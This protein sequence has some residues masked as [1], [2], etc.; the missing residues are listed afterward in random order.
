[1]KK[2][3][4]ISVEEY[5]ALKKCAKLQHKIDNNIDGNNILI[6]G[7]GRH[8][9]YV[10]KICVFGER[11][12]R[13]CDTYSSGDLLGYLIEKPSVE[14]YEWADAIIIASYFDRKNIYNK[15][16]ENKVGQEK[17]VLLYEDED[18][19][20][21]YC[22]EVE[23]D[24]S[25]ITDICS[26]E[27]YGTQNRY[28]PWQAEG[29][30]AE[31]ERD[32]EKSFF[33]E[34][35]K[36]YFLKWIMPGDKVADIGAGTGRLS[37]E[38]K[39]MGA[40][41]TAIDTSQEMLNILK[42]KDSSISTCL[43]KDSCIPFDDESFDKVVS[44]DTMIHF[45]NWKDFL[46]EHKRVVKINGY[47]IYNMFNDEHLL[48]ISAD[49]RVRTSYISDCYGYGNAVNRADI[50]QACKEIGG[51]ELVDMIPYGFLAQTAFA[52]GIL[53]HQ[54][55]L[56]LQKWYFSFF[57]NETMRRLLGKFEREIVSKES[58]TISAMNII[59][60]RKTNL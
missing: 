23:M 3:K 49:K 17:I 46:I 60:L 50:K 2:K 48:P 53:T 54:E 30:G 24:A 41:V 38:I 6:F 29:M 36:N 13:I 5:E 31:Y 19:Q 20:P 42:K 52:Y 4:V 56:S 7:A 11:Q 27:N 58:E 32:V 21:I 43:V 8:A 34:I 35:T 28:T 59:I 44:C 39:K 18:R 9:E 1:M 40:G 12:I 10:L 14:A 26:R 22:Y 16:I 57:G 33:S 47:I 55:M 37:I 25:K 51:L 15:L 45:L